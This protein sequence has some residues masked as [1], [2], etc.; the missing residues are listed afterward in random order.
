M[1]EVRAVVLGLFVLV[2]IALGISIWR[3]PAREIKHLGGFKVE[4]VKHEGGSRKHVSFHIPISVVARA[5]SFIPIHDFGGDWTRDWSD[6][7]LSARDIL[8]AADKSSPG[9]PGEIE[10]GR[11]RIEVQAD[12]AA[13]EITVKDEWDKAVRVRVPRALVESLSSEKSISPRDILRRLDEL[14]PGD[15]VVIHDRDDEVTITAEPR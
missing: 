1:K 12:G 10:R 4:V 8:D 3:R 11:K 6:G 14:G 7:D 9:K 2:L 5:A 13:I 15:V